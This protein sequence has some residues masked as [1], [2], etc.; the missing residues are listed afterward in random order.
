LWISTQFPNT[1]S[2]TSSLCSAK[3]L[4]QEDSK[5]AHLVLHGIKKVIFFTSNATILQSMWST[6][7]KLFLHIILIVKSKILWLNL[8][9]KKNKKSIYA[10]WQFALEVAILKCFFLN[11]SHGILGVNGKKTLDG[12]AWHGIRNKRAPLTN[13]SNKN[14]ACE[15]LR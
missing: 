15:M 2:K 4:S 12:W 3:V 7:L 11:R 10:I 8:K 14:D 1:I 6:F 5:F 9:I 13:N